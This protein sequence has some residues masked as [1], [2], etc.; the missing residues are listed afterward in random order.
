MILNQIL[1]PFLL[2][3]WIALAIHPGTRALAAEGSPEK[4]KQL[5]SVLHSNASVNDKARACQQAGECGTAA[6][7]PDLAALLGDEQLAAYARSGLENIPDPSA[8]AALRAALG[9]L[10]GDRLAGVI[11]SLGKLRDEKAVTDLQRL[12]ADPG[13]G[14]LTQALL[15]LGRVANKP[16]LKTLQKSLHSGPAEFRPAAAAACLLAAERQLAK[17]QTQ[18]AKKLY[19]DVRQADL[20]AP[21]RIG[22]TRGAILA[23]KTSGVGLLIELLKSDDRD[24]RNAALLTVR[25]MPS[26]SLTSAL[27]AALAKASPE[28]QILLIQALTDCPSPAAL[29]AVRAKATSETP[30]VRLAALTSLGAVGGAADVPVLLQALKTGSTPAESKLAQRGLQRLSGAAITDLL[31]QALASASEVNYR[32]ALIQLLGLRAA[33]VSAVELLKQTADPDTKI[34]L[35]ALRALKEVAE[36][37]EIPALIQLLKSN[38]D[39]EVRAAAGSVISRACKKQEKDSSGGDRVLAELKAATSVADKLSWLKILGRLGTEPA[40]RAV[41]GY[42]QDRDESLAEAA[43]KALADWP[44]ALPIGRLITSIQ[45]PTSPEHRDL[46][47]QGAVRMAVLESDS[48]QSVTWFKQLNLAV[49]S[50]SEKE[51]VYTGLIQL[52]ARHPEGMELFQFYLDDPEVAT[53]A[54]ATLI[55]SAPEMLKGKDAPLLKALLEKVAGGIGAAPVR[56]KAATL[57]KK[58]PGPGPSQPQ[59][60]LSFRPLFDGHSFDGWEGDTTNSFRIEDGAIVGGNLKTSVPRNEFLATTRLYTNFIF[61]AECKL[62]GPT[63]NGGI[64]IRTQRIPNHNE[65]IGYQADMSAGKDGGYWGTLYDESR[66][67]RGLGIRENRSQMVESLKAEGWNQYEIRCEG[68]RIQLFVNGVRTLDYTETDETISPAGIIAIQIHGGLPSETWYRNLLIAEL[69]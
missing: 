33:N 3:A 37:D 51:L 18:S 4:T 40:Y 44:N 7:V 11:D 49:R 20:P 56:Q 16:S 62:V 41:Q 60:S 24:I 45:A 50:A 31:V 30:E 23:R 36:P 53:Q 43:Y 54:A 48:P 12:A 58:I 32:I 29:V 42:L 17:G 2:C 25:E 69:P 5:I 67:R 68:P 19:D 34:K 28:L 22:A 1:K 10:K 66:R 26:P 59:T 8:T 47:F 46:A 14:V 64:Q 61:R 15:A 35:A 63:A 21:Y 39:D 38:S 55:E 6:I 13:Q 57:A 27:T 65:V 9:T 52:G